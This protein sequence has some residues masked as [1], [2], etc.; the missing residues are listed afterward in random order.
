M[1]I[2]GPLIDGFGRI[3]TDLRLS[4]TDRC[5]FRCFYC[6]PAE[7]I[8]FLPRSEILSFEEYARF[9]SVVA[10]MGVRSVRLTG[11]EPLMRQELSRLVGMLS[12]IQGIDEVSLTTNATLLAQQASDLK[13]AGLRRVNISLDALDEDIFY[14]ITRRHGLERVLEGIDAAIRVGFSPVRLN[15]VSIRGLTEN[16]AVRLALFAREKQLE[17]RFIEFMPLDADGKWNGNQVLSGEELRTLLASEIA[18]LEPLETEDPSQ[19]ATD[20]R[21]T[22]GKGRVGFIDSVTKPF[23]GDCDR[24]RLTAE[25]SIRNCLF[26][27]EEWDVRRLIREGGSDEALTELIRDCVGAKKAG[28]GTDSGDF[29]RPERAMYQIGG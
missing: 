17:L 6:M 20:Y 27:T 15:A 1:S 23:C 21:Y 29:I 3:H 7:D 16:E 11:G 5:N 24:L 19:P 18:P 12:N 13:A 14:Q 28:H 2:Q 8:Q 22:D 26:S 10:Q 4:V 25:G 9:V